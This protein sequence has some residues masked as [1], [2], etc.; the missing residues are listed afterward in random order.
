MAS[1]EDRSNTVA[2]P[3]GEHIP[4]ERWVLDPVEVAGSGDDAIQLTALVQIR[5]GCR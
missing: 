4:A 3:S 5:R 2:L 1:T